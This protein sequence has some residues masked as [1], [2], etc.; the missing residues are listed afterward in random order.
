[1][2][3]GPERGPEGSRHGHTQHQFT[4]PSH[5]ENLFRSLAGALHHRAWPALQGPGG[6]DLLCCCTGSP[7]RDA[8]N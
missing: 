1:M 3:E 7:P 4:G 6:P 2:I 8:L 5:R